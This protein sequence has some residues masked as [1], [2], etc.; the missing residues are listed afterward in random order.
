VRDPI[1]DWVG[2]LSPG[3]RY[4]L[5]RARELPLSR[6]EHSYNFAFSFD[7]NGDEFA[8]LFFWQR[9]R[10]PSDS[11]P[12][13]VM[14]LSEIGVGVLSYQ[15]A[16]CEALSVLPYGR[17]FVRDLNRDEVPDLVIGTSSLE[18]VPPRRGDTGVR[19]F[20]NSPSGFVEVLHQQWPDAR[21][22]GKTTLLDVAVAD[23][24]DDGAGLQDIALGYDRVSGEALRAEVGAL[25]FEGSAAGPAYLEPA[26][27]WSGPLPGLSD[28]PTANGQLAVGRVGE[29]NALVIGQAV[30]EQTGVQHALL[31]RPQRAGGFL[32]T[33]L[34]LPE[35]TAPDVWHGQG[36][37]DLWLMPFFD[38]NVLCAVYAGHLMVYDIEARGVGPLPVLLQQQLRAEHRIERTPG[39]GVVM[40]ERLFMDLEGDGDTDFLEMISATEEH[41]ADLVIHTSTA[42]DRFLVSDRVL[43]P[44]Y[45]EPWGPTPFA[46]VRG[47]EAGM[48][49]RFASGEQAAGPPVFH[50]MGCAE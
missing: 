14:L 32:E 36:P 26:R 21:E 15:L 33:S 30:R 31:V 45:R 25:L 29:Q 5:G 34:E 28:V 49:V 41:A 9:E 3:C 16:D 37:F 22:L 17:V 50:L 2:E 7:V 6:A 23:L 39:G 47:A 35:P 8:D 42:N 1:G 27:K 38:T 10:Q 48:L 43:V 40:Q 12:R 44:R 13:L 24:N 20:V 4:E 19:A 46:T 11:S 18:G